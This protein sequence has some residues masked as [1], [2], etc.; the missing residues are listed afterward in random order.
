MSCFAPLKASIASRIICGR[1]R[2]IDSGGL[3]FW[4]MYLVAYDLLS[5]K[6]AMCF[7]SISLNICRCYS[8]IARPTLSKSSFFVRSSKSVAKRTIAYFA[9]SWS[10]SFSK[11][12]FLSVL[13]IY[14]AL[15]CRICSSSPPVSDM[16]L[17]TDS[18]KRLVYACAT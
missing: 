1:C 3:K 12:F 6:S 2:S 15:V 10:L 18:S 17:Y 14:S 4:S 11:L 7:V 9:S 8:D 5:R 16:N 13:T